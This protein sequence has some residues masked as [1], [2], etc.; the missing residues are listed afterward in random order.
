PVARR[1]VE[2]HAHASHPSA[3]AEGLNTKVSHLAHDRDVLFVSFGELLSINKRF[4]TTRRADV[5]GGG[6]F[7]GR[8]EQNRLRHA[9]CIIVSIGGRT[10]SLPGCGHV[11]G[12]TFDYLSI[13]KEGK[14]CHA[15]S[16]SV[17]C[18]PVCACLPLVRRKP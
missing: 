18:A 6:Y 1:P 8:H 17:R 13:C 16:G 12:I 4:P 3:G 7:V 2:C 5:P 14:R 10:L 9:L 11:M 15:S